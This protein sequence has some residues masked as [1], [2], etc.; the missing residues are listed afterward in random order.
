MSLLS[1]SD[2]LSRPRFSLDTVLD[3]TMSRREFLQMGAGL[4]LALFGV[5]NLIATFQKHTY[6][7]TAP[8]SLM[9]PNGDGFGS[10]K[11]GK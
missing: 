9:T 7:N 2:D 10:R 8:S 6:R 11:F 1:P 3:Q 5:Q 4:I